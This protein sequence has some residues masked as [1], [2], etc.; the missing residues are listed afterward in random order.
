[1]KTNKYKVHFS[2][3]LNNQTWNF[4]KIFHTSDIEASIVG[5]LETRDLPMDLT[6]LKHKIK[7][8]ENNNRKQTDKKNSRNKRV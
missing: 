6:N 4:E 5:Y 1:M 8:Y 2:F 3:E 7:T